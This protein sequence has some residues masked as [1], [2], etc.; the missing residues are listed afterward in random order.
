MKEKQE[1]KEKKENR[2]PEEVIEDLRLSLRTVTFQIQQFGLEVPS[3][4]FEKFPP[5]AAKDIKPRKG[6][7]RIA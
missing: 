4:W 5:L 3:F 6:K 7:K 1:K 2:T